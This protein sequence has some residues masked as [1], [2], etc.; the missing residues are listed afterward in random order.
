V[1][2]PEEGQEEEDVE[3]ATILENSILNS[4]D[5]STTGEFDVSEGVVFFVWDNTYG[6]NP[7]KHLSYSIK[8]HQVSQKIAVFAPFFC[9]KYLYVLPVNHTNMLAV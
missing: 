4:G 7:S 3:I 8:V 2:A 6:W 5:D 9:L 1:A